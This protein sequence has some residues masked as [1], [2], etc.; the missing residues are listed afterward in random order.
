MA[1]PPVGGRD[2]LGEYPHDATNLGNPPI[3]NEQSTGI[4]TSPNNEALNSMQ[5][6][7]DKQ[8][9][10]SKGPFNGEQGFSD[11]QAS[12]GGGSTASVEYTGSTTQNNATDGPSD[13]GE[14]AVGERKGSMPLSDDNRATGAEGL[15]M[16]GHER[17]KSPGAEASKVIKPSGED[18][19]GKPEQT[20]QQSASDSVHDEHD[21]DDE[22]KEEQRPQ[23][24][25][26]METK[27]YVSTGPN[28]CEEQ[29]MLT[30]LIERVDRPGA[31]GLRSA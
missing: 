4:A 11:E 5:P 26:L 25:F 14:V 7:N 9:S 23:V 15:T 10:N 1:M 2:G 18:K 17:T 31:D 21:E 22:D 20:H 6:V 3:P 29:G 13:A 8:S 30:S 12:S 28:T 24:G 16:T 19:G 27:P